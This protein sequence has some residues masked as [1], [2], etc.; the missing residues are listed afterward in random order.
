MKTESKY[1]IDAKIK[2][3]IT[4]DPKTETMKCTICPLGKNCPDAHNPI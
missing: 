3:Q 2:K 1:Y 4:Q